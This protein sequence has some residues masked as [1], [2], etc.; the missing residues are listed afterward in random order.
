MM[1]GFSARVSASATNHT[2]QMTVLRSFTAASSPVSASRIGE[3]SCVSCSG[4][5]LTTLTKA[6]L[7]APPVPSG[8]AW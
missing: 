2:S 3:K 8:H 1:S 7:S 6:L 4:A 5:G